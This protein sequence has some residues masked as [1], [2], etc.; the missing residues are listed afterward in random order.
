MAI[1]D[2]ELQIVNNCIAIEGW[3]FFLNSIK[4]GCVVAS[5]DNY[6]SDQDPNF[7]GSDQDS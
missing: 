2:V 3:G 5:I 7:E 4:I 6:A 1:K